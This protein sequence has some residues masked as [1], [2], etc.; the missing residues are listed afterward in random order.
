MIDELRRRVEQPSGLTRKLPN[1]NEI[2][3]T[4]MTDPGIEKA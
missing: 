3:A 1:G 2:A 4:S